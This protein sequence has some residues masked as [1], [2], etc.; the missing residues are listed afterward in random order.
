[1]RTIELRAWDENNDFMFYHNE[2]GEFERVIEGQRVGSDFKV[3]D[4]LFMPFGGLI[5]S[6]FTGFLDDNKNKIYTG[7]I[8]NFGAQYESKSEVKFLPLNGAFMVK[9]KYGDWQFLYDIVASTSA[10]VIGNVFENPDLL[11]SS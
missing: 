5:G 10:R 11:Q 6:E 3:Q 8:L 9:D 1:M 2:D 4:L 7:D